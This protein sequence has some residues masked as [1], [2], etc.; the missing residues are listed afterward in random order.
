MKKKILSQ[1][2]LIFL[3]M[4]IGIFSTI[5]N[6][7]ATSKSSLS[8]S[9]N[10]KVGGNFTVTLNLPSDAYGADFTVTVKYSDGTSSSQKIAYIK[11]FQGFDSTSATFSAKVAGNATV[12]ASG[13]N[14][15]DS[16][17][18]AIETGGSTSTNIN[19]ADNTP[20]KPTEP[21]NPPTD[22]E[23][24]SGGN[25][26]GGTNPGGST[27]GDNNTGNNSGSTTPSEENKVKFTDVNETV[28][29]TESVNVRKNYSTSSE[30]ITKLSKNT[31]LTRTGVGNN[32]WSRV[33]Y[34]GQTAYISSQYLTTT[35][36]KDS[37][38]PD[39]T[40][41]KF[42][43]VNETM[44]ASQNCNL[45]KSWTTESD[46]AGYLTKGEEV[47]R[48]GIGDNGWSKIKY[49]GNVVYVATRLLTKEQPEESD[50][51]E[52]ETENL[53]ENETTDN[54]V[55]EGEKTELELL[56][57]E[58]G[59]LPEVGNNIATR[60]YLIVIL[61]AISSVCGGIYYIKRM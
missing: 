53:V 38:E 13:I 22:P 6:V 45:R 18:K 56:Q 49:N 29:T 52:I 33:N 20:P 54:E 11:G 24:P 2:L 39:E 48:I 17:G 44:Y 7:N 3:I 28:Y 55:V 50:E 21:E 10:V 14:L 15:S 35:V 47:T 40:E 43:D 26:S 5:T 34:N 36:P 23:K 51:N 31:K 37:E 8:C 9:G 27:P 12:T 30:K 46:K 61:F 1:I 19:I 57:E 16:A 32:G 41:V 60:M 42:T 4:I 58:I 59:V 25:D